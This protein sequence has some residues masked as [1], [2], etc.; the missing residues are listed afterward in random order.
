M[1]VS[2]LEVSEILGRQRRRRA[3][4]TVS[5]VLGIVVMLAFI[6]VTF[7]IIVPDSNRV[8]DLAERGDCK[9]HYDSLLA[10]QVTERGNLS[11]DLNA[12]L[13]AALLK[14]RTGVEAT[15]E[16][17]QRFLDTQQ[18]LQRQIDKVKAQ[19]ALDDAV[20]HGFVLDGRRYPPCPAVG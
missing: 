9:T 4:S 17:V 10:A 3:F 14:A 7:F 20:R 11:A 12:Q 5:A 6:I 19:P 18:A 2:D 1:A 16:V 15:P 8:R 13:G